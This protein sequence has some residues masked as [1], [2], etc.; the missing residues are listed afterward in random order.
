MR[1]VGFYYTN[2]KREVRHELFGRSSLR[3]MI[4]FLNNISFNLFRNN[5]QVLIPTH[6]IIES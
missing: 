1:V 6:V 4:E 3:G 2:T 5:T